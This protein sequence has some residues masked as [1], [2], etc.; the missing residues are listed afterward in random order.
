MGHHDGEGL[1]KRQ[2]LNAYT[3]FILCTLGFG[4]LTYGYTASIIG[5]TL[6]Q[7]SFI[8]YFKLNTRP[9]ATDLISSTNGLFQTGGF[10]GTLFRRI[11]ETED[12][13]D[14]IWVSRRERLLK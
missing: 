9:D 4:S 13:I 11:L 10:L 7:P 12:I 5:T 3:L 2:K 6:G 14:S 8:E 1:L